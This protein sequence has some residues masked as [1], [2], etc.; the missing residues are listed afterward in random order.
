MSLRF[1]RQPSSLRN[2]QLALIITII[3]LIKSKSREFNKTNNIMLITK[4]KNTLNSKSKNITTIS[5]RNIN[6][7]LKSLKVLKFIHRLKK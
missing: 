1:K 5:R 3:T 4:N 6:I 2:N 7:R